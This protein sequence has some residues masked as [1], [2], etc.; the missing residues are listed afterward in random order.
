M[1]PEELLRRAI[2]ACPFG[3]VIVEPLGNIVFA[4]GALERMFGYAPAALI[5]ESV[6]ILVPTQALP[7]LPRSRGRL[8]AASA[9]NSMAGNRSLW[10]RR[11]DGG[12][13]PIELALNPMQTD[14]GTL[15]LGTVVDIGERLR[16]ERVKDEFV[17]TMSHELRT[18]LTSIAGAL[19]LLVRDADEALSGRSARLLKIAYANSQRLVRLVNTIL[20][21]EKIESGKIMFVLKRV[22]V[23]SLVEQAIEANRILADGHGV[24]LR[25]DAGATDYEVRGDADWLVQVVANLLSNAIK[26]SP[27]GEEVLVAVCKDGPMV[28]V[29]VR[30]HGRGVPEGFKPRIFERFAQADAT[31]ARERGGTGLGLSIVK[32]IVTRLGGRVSFDDAPG[33][34]TIFFVDL[35]CWERE[36]TAASAGEAPADGPLS[37][38]EAE[39][40]AHR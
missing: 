37:S 31:D 1:E 32:E 9:G 3:I 22:E 4:N 30:D 26:F 12:E 25:L 8:A 17:A 10:G 39:R 19:G 33:G 18:P 28:R 38:P 20:E 7:Q 27:P 2:D 40:R 14:A 23:R 13:F 24:H 29:S 16:G 15:F 35:P 34:G 21:M 11:R 6:D 36:M 5:G